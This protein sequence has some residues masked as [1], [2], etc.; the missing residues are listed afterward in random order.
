MLKSHSSIDVDK[1]ADFRHMFEENK[2]E[3]SSIIMTTFNFIGDHG[4]NCL[5]PKKKDGKSFID[6]V[7]ILEVLMK[8]YLNLIFRLLNRN[9]LKGNKMH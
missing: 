7:L 6:L 3:E 4:L 9:F 2:A 5:V 1:K 8:I